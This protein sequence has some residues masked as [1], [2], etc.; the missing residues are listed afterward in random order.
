MSYFDFEDFFETEAHLGE[1]LDSKIGYYHIGVESRQEDLERFHQRY[2]AAAG[3]S[4]SPALVGIQGDTRS[5]LLIWYN[6]ATD[7][8]KHHMSRRELGGVL[9]YDYHI[10]PPQ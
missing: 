5:Q 7:R 4:A 6:R 10:K 3:T 8:Y 9:P 1:I 2:N